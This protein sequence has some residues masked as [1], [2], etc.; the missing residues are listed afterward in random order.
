MVL[1]DGKLVGVK[2]TQQTNEREIVSMMVG[3]DLGALETS[4]RTKEPGAEMLRVEGFSRKGV[5]EN[6]SFKL[7]AGEV[8]TFFGLVGRR[9]D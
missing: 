6:V 1:R 3:R 2:P 7:Q 4:A 9:P 5:F 8:L